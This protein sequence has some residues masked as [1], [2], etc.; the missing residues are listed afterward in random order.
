[1]H[2]PSSAIGGVSLS[3][4]AATRSTGTADESKDNEDN[5]NVDQRQDELVP[6]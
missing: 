1:V 5:E 2:V 4:Q 6:S 3:R